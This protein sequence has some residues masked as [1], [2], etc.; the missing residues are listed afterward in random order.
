MISAQSALPEEGPTAKISVEEMMPEDIDEILVIESD[1]FPTPWSGNLFFHELHNPL[2][3]NFVAKINKPGGGEIAGYMSYWIVADELHLQH[4]AT[5]ADLRRTGIA[6]L[7]C[8]V[9]M[10]RGRSEGAQRAT[11]EVRRSNKG[12]IKLYEK[13]G[14]VAAG[15]RR[16][17]YDDTHEDA[18]IMW[19]DIK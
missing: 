7:L 12:A 19:A 17:Y 3:R 18:L 10:Q 14:F 16:G 9:M 5:R 4:I 2:A 15:V 13:T 1:S 11:L 8:R 6:S